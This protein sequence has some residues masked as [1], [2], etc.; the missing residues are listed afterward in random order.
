MSDHDGLKWLSRERYGRLAQGYVD[1]P[2]HARGAD[3]DRLIEAVAPRP[4]WRALDVATGGGHAALKLAPHVAQVVA[5]DL[6]PEM[7]EAARSFIH[8]QG[9]ANVDFQPADAENLPFESASFDLVT[10]RIAAHHFPHCDRFV[11]EGARVLVPGGVLWVQDH[12]LSEDA[13]TARYTDGFEKLRDPSHHHAFPESGWRA[14]FEDAGLTVELTERVVKRHPFRPWARRQ[15]CSDGVI[16][17]LETLLCEAPP[18]AAEWMAPRD[19]G[20]PQA[21]FVNRH[22]LILGRKTA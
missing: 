1:S 19:L 21:S 7:L 5:A 12:V 3:L 11:A 2:A 14:M 4:D 9:A 17:Q 8:E 15:D 22:L 10:C 13:L 6:T 20:T 16:R 18:G